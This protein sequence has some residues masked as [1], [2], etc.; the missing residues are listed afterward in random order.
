[1]I[2]RLQSSTNFL[3]TLAGVVAMAGPATLA[4]QTAQARSVPVPPGGGSIPVPVYT[5]ADIYG[6]QQETWETI[7]TSAWDEDNATY[8]LMG[9]VTDV[10]TYAGINHHGEGFVLDVVFADVVDW[11]D[12][13][14]GVDPDDLAYGLAN[15]FEYTSV[16][17]VLSTNL[18]S[19]PVSGVS[20]A[21]NELGLGDTRFMMYK[22]EDPDNALF[23]TEP[24]EE[25]DTE[26]ASAFNCVEIP[27]MC[28]DSGCEQ[29]CEDAYQSEL[30]AA[31]RE[32]AGSLADAETAYN[33][34]VGPA[35]A[36][37][38]N[39][40]SDANATYDTATIVAKAALAAALLR[41]TQIVIQQHLKCARAASFLWFAA[42]AAQLLCVAATTVQF[43]TCSGSSIQTYSTAVDTAKVL[44]DGKIA[45]AQIAFNQI[46]G[47]ADAA[48]AQSIEDANN[49]LAERL[50][51]A[52]ATKQTCL[53]GCIPII[54]DHWIMCYPVGF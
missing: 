8:P 12:P 45:L 38:N 11:D 6:E 30:E 37:L 15:D 54:C 46:E 51:D 34:I 10:G 42:A 13:N 39:A 25:G 41:C 27:V 53:D 31:N 35:Q 26:D 32:H 43:V 24:D 1:M 33:D 44:R 4:M 47:P 18:G 19:V 2:R 20:V 3:Y 16:M 52:E 29:A 23:Q 49:R 17:G 14:M 9:H 50:R 21:S 48:R 36:D 5:V 22:M 40:I 7:F 28:P